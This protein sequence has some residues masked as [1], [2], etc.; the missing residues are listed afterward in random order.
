MP[1]LQKAPGTLELSKGYGVGN[2]RGFVS[3]RSQE[4][5]KFQS[6]KL[7]ET[8]RKTAIITVSVMVTSDRLF[9]RANARVNQQFTKLGVLP[10]TRS[11]GFPTPCLNENLRGPQQTGG[12]AP[13]VRWRDWCYRGAGLVSVK[14]A[15]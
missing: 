7:K 12:D 9:R 6:L 3:G 14:N 1:S 2:P 15:V 5:L 10:L 13:E 8:R 4:L 11:C